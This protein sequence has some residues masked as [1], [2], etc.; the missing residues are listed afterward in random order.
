[1]KDTVFTTIENLQWLPWVGKNYPQL[2]PQKRLLIIGESHYHDESP[3]SIAKH[4]NPEFTRIVIREMAMDRQYYSTKIFPNLH[5]A[6]FGNDTFDAVA[7]WE[8]TAFY[9][10]IQRPM[11][12]NQSRPTKADW[13][14]A[15]DVFFEVAEVLKPAQVLFTSIEAV[16]QLKAYAANKGWAEPPIACGAYIG[17]TYPRTTEL[18][19]P[20]GHKINVLFIKHPSQYFSWRKWHEV[21]GEQIRPSAN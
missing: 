14:Q 9:N 12:T 4:Q 18:Q 15:W 1:M 6:L 3:E 7:F 19:T 13:Q 11:S 20:S 17:K 10:F 8:Q 21:V 5:K 2:D 16:H